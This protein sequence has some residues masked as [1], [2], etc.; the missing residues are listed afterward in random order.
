MSTPALAPT[1]QVQPAANDVVNDP[2]ARTSDS[3]PAFTT[4]IG[5]ACKHMLAATTTH[6]A[7]NTAFLIFPPLLSP[8]SLYS[9]VTGSSNVTAS[10]SSQACRPSLNSVSA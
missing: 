5:P 3:K 4:V 7:N 10:P 6:T 1:V 8:Q 9:D 2:C